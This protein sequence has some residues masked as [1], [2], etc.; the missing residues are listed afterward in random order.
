MFL[1]CC[2]CQSLG[3]KCIKLVNFAWISLDFLSEVSP[4]CMNLFFFI[5]RIKQ[6]QPSV[7]I[8][9]TQLSQFN[10][11]ALGSSQWQKQR[12]IGCYAVWYNEGNF[13][14]NSSRVKPKVKTSKYLQSCKLNHN[15]TW[16]PKKTRDLTIIDD[17]RVDTA[18][19]Q[20]CNIWIESNTLLMV[21]NHRHTK[22]KI[23]K[24]HW[25]YQKREFLC[26]KTTT[27]HHKC[28]VKSWLISKFRFTFAEI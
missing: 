10:E 4:I 28:A 25:W 14:F 6:D 19:L 11:A 2:K 26:R 21:I 16:I 5:L 13:R 22:N 20:Y 17:T 12:S 27:H 9:K 3:W 24:N 7:N 23:V 1:L 18:V 8:N 15:S